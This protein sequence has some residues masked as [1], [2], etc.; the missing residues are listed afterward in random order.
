MRS[1]TAAGHQRITTTFTAV[2]IVTSNEGLHPA[3]QILFMQCF[4]SVEASDTRLQIDRSAGVSRRTMM[5]RG[6][7]TASQLLSICRFLLDFT[8]EPDTL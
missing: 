2:V 7:L 8:I 5:I 3:V 6:A 1:C 4:E